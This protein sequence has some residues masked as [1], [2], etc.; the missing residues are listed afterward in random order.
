M[1]GGRGGGTGGGD[2]D[3]GGRAPGK[4]GGNSNNNIH[5]VVSAQNSPSHLLVVVSAQ[6]TLGLTPRFC[7]A[8]AS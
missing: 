4:G 8:G 2:R 6:C 5:A 3:G 1:G 7:G